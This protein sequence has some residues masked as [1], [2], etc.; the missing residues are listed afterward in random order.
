MAAGRSGTNA[1]IKEDSS[2]GAKEIQVLSC[3]FL[4]TTSKT[5]VASDEEEDMAV[6]HGR[7]PERAERHLIRVLLFK[8]P[9]R[10]Q[11]RRDQ[12]CHDA[13]SHSAPTSSAAAHSLPW[14]LLVHELLRGP[15]SGYPDDDIPVRSAL[16]SQPFPQ[17]H[18]LASLQR[19]LSLVSIHVS[20]PS[21]AQ[22]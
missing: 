2:S 15:D 3:V 17:D 11:P 1:E 19:L 5:A 22:W 8:R 7:L 21:L 10:A 4:R 6:G 13:A 14:F 9:R 16:R 18:T 20:E 12:I